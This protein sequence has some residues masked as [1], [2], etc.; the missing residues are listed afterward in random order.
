LAF[1][2]VFILWCGRI[3]QQRQWTKVHTL[4]I[5]LNCGL[6]SKSRLSLP[7]ATPTYFCMFTIILILNSQWPVADT[8]R[9]N[10]GG[11][12]WNYCWGGWL[13]RWPLLVS[14]TGMDFLGVRGGAHPTKNICTP[15]EAF[16]TAPKSF[17][18]PANYIYFDLIVSYLNILTVY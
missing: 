3:A 12:N 9:N 15:P 2:T 1:C 17:C 5:S 7:Q 14:D 8:L 18:T 4:G 11:G 6:T 10:G 16:G 13:L